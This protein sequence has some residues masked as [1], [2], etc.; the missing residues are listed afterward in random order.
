VLLC[1]KIPILPH[2]AASHKMRHNT[3]YEMNQTPQHVVLATRARP[4]ARRRVPQTAA[5]GQARARRFLPLVVAWPI[6]LNRVAP[7]AGA[8]CRRI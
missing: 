2:R 5:R 8:L 4:A 3:L 7:T 6:D 1:K